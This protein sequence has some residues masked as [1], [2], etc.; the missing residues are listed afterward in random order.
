[1]KP[2]V[3]VDANAL[4]GLK[5]FTKPHFK[6]VLA[7]SK[8]NHVRLVMPEVVVH[9][10]ARQGAKEFNGKHS[11]LRNAV[12]G[13]ND[14]IGDAQTMGVAVA[15][16]VVTSSTPPLTSREEFFDAMTAF[17]HSRKAETP[18]HPDMSVEELLA[19]DLDYRK[20]FA[21]NGKGFRDA[22]IWATIRDMCNALTIPDVATVFVTKNYTDFCSGQGKSLHNHL[23]EELA[24]EQPFDVVE[25]LAALLEHS[26]I[27]PL[28][29]SLRVL[30]Q[31]FT[32]ERL[33][34]L[35]D[36]A[37]SDLDGQDLEQSIGVYEGD[38]FT[39]IP[40][41][42]EL[43]DTAF[44][45]IMPENDTIEHDVF[46]TGDADEMTIRVTVDADCSI[47]G[48]LDKAD[49]FAHG[50]DSFTYSEDWNRHTMRASEPHRIRFTLSADF[51]KA[52]INDV[53]LSVDE[54]EEAPS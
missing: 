2:L 11:T 25:D 14:V 36:A 40:I 8:T 46:R 20:P 12:Q 18:T 15:P 28:T 41:N 44:G 53:Q 1:M 3:F 35:V 47:E 19:R 7:L 27:K 26:D 13:F 54:A 42:T 4:H 32:R 10:L 23:R 50:S 33:E 45:E 16:A 22:L 52:T 5:A 37:L 9:E 24:P 43:S 48:F 6:T 49:Y 31:T 29:E 39:S 51:T 38:G 21:E 34:G 17:L 30:D